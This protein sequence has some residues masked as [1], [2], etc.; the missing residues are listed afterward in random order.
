MAPQSQS[1]S[2]TI[3]INP[4]S[5]SPLEV[6][7]SQVPTSGTVGVPFVGQLVVTGGVAPYSY[8]LSSG[9][10][11]DGVSLNSDGSFSGTPTTAGSFAF[12]VTV[13]DSES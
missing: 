4:A 1:V 8:S 3:T 2:I 12:G 13:T 7:A 5:P 9:A 11:P 6:D 10:L